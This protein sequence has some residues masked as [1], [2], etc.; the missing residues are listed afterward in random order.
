[1]I[2]SLLDK[3]R[4]LE[5][6]TAPVRSRIDQINGSLEQAREASL[7]ETKSSAGDKYETG[8]EMMRI[9]SD[10]QALHLYE[11]QDLLHRLERID[12]SQRH[13]TVRPGAVVR[14]ESGLYFISQSLG[15]VR[16]DDVEYQTM[17]LASPLGKVLK[18]L[19]AGDTVPFR[20][21]T[22]SVLAVF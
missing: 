10:M 22:V 4:L 1:M 21:A 20:E 3:K 13:S 11:A 12:V 15:T 18:G 5:A 16:L 8:R 6:C 2:D 14:T 7:Q 19:S 17:S 9:Q